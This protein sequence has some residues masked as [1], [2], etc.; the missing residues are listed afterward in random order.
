MPLSGRYVYALILIG[1]LLGR[2]PPANAIIIESFRT[3]GYTEDG[4]YTSMAS[5]VQNYFVGYTSPSSPTERRNYFVFSLAPLG[6]TPVIGGALRLYIPKFA[7]GVT[8]DPGDGYNSPDATETYR[9][10]E[11]PVHPSELVDPTNSVPEA[12][13]YWGT[14]G[15]GTSFGEITVGA[16]AMGFDIDIPLT[17]AAI[18]AINSVPGGGSIA[19]GGRLMSLLHRESVLDELLFSFSDIP[20]SGDIDLPRLDLI[21][22]PEPT[23]GLGLALLGMWMFRRCRSRP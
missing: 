5:P 2:V 3:G 8:T 7:P 14:L 16:G 22:A 10:S 1:A 12:V 6:G 15:T 17:P 23:S 20:G 11:T 21:M 9:I 13:G 19:I 18:A 4:G